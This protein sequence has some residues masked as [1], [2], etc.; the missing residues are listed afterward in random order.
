M[1]CDPELGNALSLAMQS[2][3][4]KRFGKEE[5]MRNVKAEFIQAKN[6]LER[7]GWKFSHSIRH[8]DEHKQFGSVYIKGAKVFYLN[9]YTINNLPLNEEVAK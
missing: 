8:A 2:E 3:Y 4:R 1:K 5:D 6:T 7:Y 9:L